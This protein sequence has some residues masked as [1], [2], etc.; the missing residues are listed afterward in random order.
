MSASWVPAEIFVGG[1]GASPK[2]DPDVEKS[3]KK[4]PQRE[5]S[6][7]KSPYI[8]NIFFRWGGRA[9]TLAPTPSGCPWTTWL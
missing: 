3:T 6:S 4:A 1:G 7:E 5:K 9:L 8:V 2:K